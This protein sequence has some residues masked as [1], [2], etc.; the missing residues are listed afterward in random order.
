MGTECKASVHTCFY[1]IWQG[2]HHTIIA[3]DLCGVIISYQLIFD[4]ATAS[5]SVHKMM[6]DTCIRLYLTHADVTQQICMYNLYASCG[7]IG[8][9]R[10]VIV[11]Y[12]YR[13]E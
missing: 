6:T 2:T 11:A 4:T 7:P 1:N 8:H 9:T 12:L 3:P 13:F 10:C 5:K